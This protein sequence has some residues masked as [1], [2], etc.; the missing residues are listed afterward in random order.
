MKKKDPSFYL[1]LSCSCFSSQCLGHWSNDH[2]LQN[3]RS[4]WGR[5][6]WFRGFEIWRWGL[7]DNTP[8]VPKMGSQW[9]GIPRLRT[10]RSIHSQW[11]KIWKGKC[12]QNLQT[13]YSFR[14]GTHQLPTLGRWPYRYCHCRLLVDNGNSVGP[15]SWEAHITSAMVT[16]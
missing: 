12:E 4:F 14:N 7:P 16:W 10:P 15:F 2:D 13:S 6:I 9:D 11:W 1:L 8:D 5:P 3:Q